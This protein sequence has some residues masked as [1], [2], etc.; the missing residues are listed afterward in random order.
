MI[1]ESI[2]CEALE[3]AVCSKISSGEKSFAP[4]ADSAIETMEL[5]HMR[6]TDV[7]KKATLQ[8]RDIM[9][10]EDENQTEGTRFFN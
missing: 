9:I 1:R 7:L 2:G 5:S 8:S 3:G 6:G 4:M 10:E